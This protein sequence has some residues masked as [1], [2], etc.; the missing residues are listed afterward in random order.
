MTFPISENTKIYPSNSHL[1]CFKLKRFYSQSNFRFGNYKELYGRSPPEI[2]I[3]K[4]FPDSKNTRSYPKGINQKQIRNI[5]LIIW[6]TSNRNL[7]SQAQIRK[8][9]R[10]I[11]L[12]SIRLLYSQ[13]NSRFGK[14]KELCGRPPT[15]F[16]IV[17][18]ISD[19]KNTNS[20]QAD[21]HQ[22]IL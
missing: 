3:V 22:N 10:V 5:Q 11:R 15:K 13:S 4:L 2:F 7:Y 1:N 9:Q 19:S 6:Q 20:Y 8:I 14:Y 17:K 18:P 12:T 21:L 16:F